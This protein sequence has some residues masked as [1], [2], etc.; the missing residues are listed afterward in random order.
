[1]ETL[2]DE[3]IKAIVNQYKKKR[4][5]ENRKY[6]EELK[7][8]P[9]WIKSNREKSKLYYHTHKDHYKEKYNDNKDFIRIRN[10]YQYYLRNNKVEIFKAKHPEKYKYLMEKGY[11]L[12]E[13]QE[14]KI[15]NI[16][17]FFKIVDEHQ[18]ESM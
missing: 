7:N 10:L 5:R 15:N 1:M 3:K 17:T 13:V 9:E 16:E 12:P 8:D 14:K 4:E 6:N 18:D 11:K 2:S